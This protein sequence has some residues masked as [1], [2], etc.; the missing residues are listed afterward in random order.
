MV[1]PSYHA[2]DTIMR[3]VE[4]ALSQCAGDVAIVVV[5]DD[6]SQSTLRLLQRRH[7]DRIHLLMNEGN[8][9]APASRNRGL[10]MVRSPHVAFL[11]ADDFYKGDFLGP[12]I[13]KMEA[14]QADIGFGP[15]LYW[16]ERDGLTH[17]FVPDYQDNSD[18]FYRWFSGINSVNTCSVVW[19]TS[20]LREIG[21]WDET[22]ERNQDG[23]LALRAI[24]MGAKFSMSAEGA[25]VWFNDVSVPSITTRKDNLDRLFDVV[26]KFE[27]MPSK[28][29]PDQVRL[30]ACAAQLHN[31]AHVSYRAGMDAVGAEAI[32]R[33]RALGF[34]NRDGEL[35]DRISVGLRVLPIPVRSLVWQIAQL[36]RQAVR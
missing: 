4:S 15:S 16:N 24:L 18:V 29:V 26:R 31:I 14:E 33:R 20:Y 25:G 3:A 36:I 34:R 21:G 6:C 7:D 35:R 8:V 19:R 5:I 32:R 13:D 11:D 12:L 10:A 23:E 27:R 22:I 17:T 30:R 9:G 2:E 28:F 1:I